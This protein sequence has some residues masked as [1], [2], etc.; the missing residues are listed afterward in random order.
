MQIPT[1]SY[2]DLTPEE[3]E[4]QRILDIR[5]AKE[6]IGKVVQ[7][8]FREQKNVFTEEDY[9]ERKQIALDVQK[10]L[11][12]GVPFDTVAQKY[13]SQYSG[14]QIK[15]GSGALP[16]EI[17]FTG[18]ENIDTFPHVS[19]AYETAMNESYAIDDTGNPVV[20]TSTGYT[21]TVLKNR[22]EDTGYDYSYISVDGTPTGWT[23]AMT[24]DGKVLND[25]YLLSA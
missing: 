13:T 9:A 18:S 8:E 16:V 19:E 12:A 20:Q 4:K 15:S 3:Q 7:L 10:D 2:A 6:T 14:V 1:K 21:V 22:T 5:N 23:P 24:K 17:A 11:T 25:Q